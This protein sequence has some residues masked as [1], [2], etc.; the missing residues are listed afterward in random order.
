MD[1]EDC[2][3]KELPDGYVLRLL[4]ALYGLKQA[5]RTW[6]DT[7]HDVFVVQYGFTRL[8]ADHSLYIQRDGE[9][10]I[11]VLLYV[12]D[13]ALAS[14]SRE[15]LDKFKLL[16]S[17]EKVAGAATINQDTSVS[18]AELTPGKQLT[19]PL[20]KKR[21]AW[22]HVIHGE[23][24]VNGKSLKTGDAVAADDEELLDVTAKGAANS[25]VLLFDLA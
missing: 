9:D 25:E 12:D 18:V 24:T 17:P 22:L 21:H 8:E 11:I 10:F 4:K 7:I 5:G 2:V 15:K 1:G 23:V 19:Y 3:W 6:Y 20:G 13:L 16:A 14:N